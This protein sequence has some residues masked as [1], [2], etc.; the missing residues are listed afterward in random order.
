MEITVGQP[1]ELRQ[2]MRA[3]FWTAQKLQLNM[4]II[5][6]IIYSQH[7]IITIVVLI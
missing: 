2:N 5:I 6:G 3:N 1:D 7:L 4:L